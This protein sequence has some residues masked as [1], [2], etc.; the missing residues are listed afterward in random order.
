MS[1]L[2][3]KLDDPT[4]DQSKISYQEHFEL[5]YLR[6]KYFR[7]STNP[8]PQRLGEFE[9]MICNISDKIYYKNIMT[10]KIIGFE[11]DDLRN[12]GRINTVSF[13]SMSGLKE[14]PTLMTK[15][16]ADHKAKFGQNS[17][18]SKRD[19]F[20]RE[21]YNLS[22]YLNQRLQE[23]AFFCEK[24]NNNIIADKTSKHYFIGNPKKNPEDES[25]MMNP[26]AFGYKKITELQYKKYLK[27]YNP[28]NANQFLIADNLLVRVVVKRANPEAIS[29]F[30]NYTYDGESVSDP[31]DILI[32]REK[33]LFVKKVVSSK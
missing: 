18:P 23:V 19:I 2:L 1:D 26:Q 7:K 17:E 16:I 29:D 9:E 14:N 4:I 10:F 25:L 20:L 31:E 11:E 22:K 8:S 32:E 5:I 12:I 30:Y 15:F 21:C 27:E 6:H 28:K 24:K 3:R 13:I 33:M